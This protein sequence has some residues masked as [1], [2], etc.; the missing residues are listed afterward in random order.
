VVRD[1]IGEAV[2]PILKE[3]ERLREAIAKLEARPE[4][5]ATY[6]P[7]SNTGPM[8]F[9]EASG[10]WW[11]LD[12]SGAVISASW[13]GAVADGAAD[14]TSALLAWRDAI[15]VSTAENVTAV[16]GSGK[17]RLASGTATNGL[18]IAR[19]N[20]TIDDAGA[21]ITVTGTG[22]IPAVFQTE[23]RNN[24]TYRNIRFYGNCQADAFAN[25]AAIWY[26][27]YLG[28]SCSGLLVEHC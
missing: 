12:I 13:F 17:Y 10:N 15:N 2:K 22:V 18:V 16:L 4:L 6:I 28:T 1:Y 3:I 21:S 14:D 8:A 20:V 27:N 25:G 26:V 23:C 7:G 11:E 24:I 19:D 9:Q 5:N